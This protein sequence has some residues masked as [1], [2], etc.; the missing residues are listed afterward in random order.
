MGFLPGAGCV[1]RGN[2]FGECGA[3][4]GC[5][6][7]SRFFSHNVFW[8]ASHDAL[9]PEAPRARSSRFP[10]LWVSSSK[11]VRDSAIEESIAL[12][13]MGIAVSVGVSLRG[14]KGR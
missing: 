2:E 5:A 7:G 9:L 13:A 1:H 6:N 11:K 4:D 14:K 3:K 12:M 8:C 10:V